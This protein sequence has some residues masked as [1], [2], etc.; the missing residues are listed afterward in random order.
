MSTRAT[1][2]SIAGLLAASALLAG[3]TSQPGSASPAQTRSTGQPG[4]AADDATLAVVPEVVDRVGPSVVTIQRPRSV[5][6]G[7]VYRSNGLIVTNAHVVGRAQNVTVIFADGTRVEGTVIGTD[8]VTDLAVVRVPRDNLPVPPYAD[9]LPEKGELAIAIGSSLGF[10]ATS[11]SVGVVSGLG[12]ELP[13]SVLQGERSLVNLIQTDAAISPGNSGGALVDGQGRIIG[14]TQ[15]YIPPET[16]AVSIGFAIP[17]TTVTFIVDQLLSGGP[18]EHPFLGV[19]LKPLTPRLREALNVQAEAGAV[20][21]DIAS[22][23][24]AAAAGLEPGDVIVRFAGQEVGSV[25]NLLGALR[26]TRPG[27]RVPVT[28]VRNGQRIQLRVTVGERPS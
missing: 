4:I 3:C 22:G 25:A 17:S 24:P 27:Q 11:V 16:G 14:I 20:V 5:G 6:S 19:V 10:L 8:R 2:A 26:S 23:S 7:V 15:A 9:A 28:V 18:V 12:R 1:R 13:G 21:V